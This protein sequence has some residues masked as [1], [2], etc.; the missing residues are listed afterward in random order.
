MIA[1]IVK[2]ENKDFHSLISFFSCLLYIIL[3][4]K[5]VNKYIIF[6]KHEKKCEFVWEDICYVISTLMQIHFSIRKFKEHKKYK[7]NI[8]LSPLLIKM[9]DAYKLVVTKI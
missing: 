3:S 4:L 2:I 1:L 8:C 9:V 5:F 7:E 6:P